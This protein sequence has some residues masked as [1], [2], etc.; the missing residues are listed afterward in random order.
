M[1]DRS[2]KWHKFLDGSHE[3][4]NHSPL[5]LEGVKQKIEK[6]KKYKNYKEMVKEWPGWNGRTK[7]FFYEEI[8]KSSGSSKTKEI[9]NF[10]DLGWEERDKTEAQRWI[11][12]KNKILEESEKRKIENVSK[13]KSLIN[14]HL[15]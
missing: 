10:F 9:Y 11:S 8:F 15:K 14:S 6:L 4:I 13:V 3:T 2:N 12:R 7:T 5:N 1:A